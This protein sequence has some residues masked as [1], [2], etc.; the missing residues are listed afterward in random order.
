[1]PKG[2][3]DAEGF[4]QALDDVR[5]SRELTWKQVAD[6]SEVSASTLTR[7]AQGRRPDVDSLAA[8]LKWSGLSADDFIV[9]GDDSEVEPPSPLASIAAQ[10]RRDKKL[11]PA[12]KK[13]IEA[14]LR[15]MYQH[16]R[17]LEDE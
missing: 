16:F 3:F 17:H 13:A 2:I 11:P 14:T 7:M 6:E 1:M 5:S 9:D 15:A 10:F 12:G 4:F 8:L